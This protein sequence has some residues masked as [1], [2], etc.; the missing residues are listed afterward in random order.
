MATHGNSKHRYEEQW[1]L[2]KPGSLTVLHGTGAGL[3]KMSRL[4]T[5]AK[6]W[7]FPT[8]TKYKALSRHHSLVLSCLLFYEHLKKGLIGSWTDQAKQLQ[9]C[10]TQV[11]LAT[12]LIWM[13]TLVAEWTLAKCWRKYGCIMCS[14]LKALARNRATW[15]E[16]Q[17]CPWTDH[18][19]QLQ[20]Q[21]DIIRS[22]W[23]LDRTR[24]L[25]DL[26]K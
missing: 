13:Q 8:N 3:W 21:V 15:R 7:L 1:L 6:Q 11:Q 5:I 22:Q 17:A 14:L 20:D 2:Q 24:V 16:E 9:I 10:W 4:G 19:K 18:T 25:I 26:G 23:C 12:S